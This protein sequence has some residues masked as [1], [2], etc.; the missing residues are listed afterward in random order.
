MV[1]LYEYMNI[2]ESMV[3][4][5]VNIIHFINHIKKKSITSYYL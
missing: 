2:Y 1:E 4:N 5:Y 3:M